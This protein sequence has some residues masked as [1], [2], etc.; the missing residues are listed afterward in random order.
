[1]LTRYADG[2]I[3]S[4]ALD[5]EL[6]KDFEGLD[7]RVAELLD[8]AEPSAALDTIWERVRRC[9]RYVE[10]HAPWQLAKDPERA[11]ELAQVLASLAEG[12]RVVTVLLHPYLPATVARLLEALGCPDDGY[13]AARFG[14]RGT[15]T[16]VREL[17][18]LFPK[19]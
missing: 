1:M 19:R 11:G 3:P 9:N 6:A 8:R 13:A 10:E 7:A 15:G 16:P 17:E 12:L 18:P 2:A 14:E 5:A 4:V